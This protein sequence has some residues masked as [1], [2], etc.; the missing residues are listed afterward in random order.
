[1][2]NSTLILW[3]GLLG[4]FAWC[5]YWH[6]QE[7]R[8]LAQHWKDSLDAMQSLWL[9]RFAWSRSIQLFLVF[10]CAA[11][12]II[13]Y[14]IKLDNAQDKVTELSARKSLATANHQQPYYPA[15]ITQP[16]ASTPPP[17]TAAIH[18]PSVAI[19]EPAATKQPSMADVYSTDDNDAQ[20]A[21]DTLK[22]RYEDMLV[23][24]F[25]LDRCGKIDKND[26]YI[27][28]AAL[29]QEMAAINASG[30]MQHDVL[31]AAQGSYNEMYAKSPCDS[32]DLTALIAQ[33]KNYVQ[34]LSQYFKR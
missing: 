9:T 17:A 8:K 25:F 6:V 28:M 20:S 31:T 21:M 27:I 23:I 32:V 18:Q 30:R 13:F 19:P 1:M 24:H 16:A 33:Y 2:F 34:A 3:V 14:S 26:Y 10:A 7:N 4:V 12:M 29:G 15:T 22:Q 11:L 5:V